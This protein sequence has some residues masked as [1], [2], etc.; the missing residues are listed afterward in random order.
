MFVPIFHSKQVEGLHDGDEDAD[1]DVVAA[2]AGW[3]R[4]YRSSSGKACCTGARV[5]RGQSHKL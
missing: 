4:C 1:E 5:L 2:V 3:R